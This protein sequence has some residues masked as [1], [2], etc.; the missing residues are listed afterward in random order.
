MLNER[1]SPKGQAKGDCNSEMAV[2][3]CVKLKG[4]MLYGQG[5]VAIFIRNGLVKV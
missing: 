1:S 3:A 4:Q 2:G 5:S